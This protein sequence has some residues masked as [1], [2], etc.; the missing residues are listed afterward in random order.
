LHP[1]NNSMRLSTYGR[2]GGEMKQRVSVNT[3]RRPIRFVTARSPEFA[4]EIVL[5]GEGA[6]VEKDNQIL[7][8]PAA[9]P[10]FTSLSEAEVWKAVNED[11]LQRTRIAGEVTRLV[12]CY[13]S[14][15]KAHFNEQRYVAPRLLHV[16]ARCPIEKVA[17]LLLV[18]FVED[19][20]GTACPVTFH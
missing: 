16:E 20:T 1:L 6:A 10:E 3:L 7:E 12:A 17:I 19:E 9:R 5:F 11:P 18:K 13:W 8:L 14:S 4:R 2:A 15:F